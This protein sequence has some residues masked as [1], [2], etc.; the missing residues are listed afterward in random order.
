M[1]EQLPFELEEEQVTAVMKSLSNAYSC[2]V[3][4][5]GTGKTTVLQLI[6]RVYLSLGY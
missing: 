4:G 5:A 1:L 3:G 2:I 6:T